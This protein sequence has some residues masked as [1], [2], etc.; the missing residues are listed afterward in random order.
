MEK[1]EMDKELRAMVDLSNA[2]HPFGDDD[3]AVV[4]RIL[5]WFNSK[6]G[7]VSQKTAAV[8]GCEMV[9][10]IRNTLADNTKQF[11]SAA[12]LFDAVDPKLEFQ[13][14]IT[15]GYWLQIFKSQNGFSGMD[16]N[17]ELKHMGHGISNITDA[18]SKAKE[19]KPALVVQ[20]QKSGSSKQA[21][22]L[23]K[24]THAG[25]RWVESRLN[26]AGATSETESEL[27]KY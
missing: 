1:S 20:T 14:A 8:P 11:S 4:Q 16:V 24:L 9:G 23:Y 12:E 6:Y 19:K 25:V 22:K 27:A 2:M 18:F 21:R 13:K 5:A 15:I 10:E 3:R 17:R 7:H 26:G